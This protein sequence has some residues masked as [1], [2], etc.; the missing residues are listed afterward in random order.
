MLFLKDSYIKK[1]EAKIISYENNKLIL[2][3]TAFY[4]KGGGQPGDVGKIEIVDKPINNN[5]RNILHE[6]QNYC[7]KLYCPLLSYSTIT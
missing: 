5:I 6:F 1:F 3:K 4:A 7:N 2:D